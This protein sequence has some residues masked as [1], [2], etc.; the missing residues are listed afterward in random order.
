[1][2]C[3]WW[4]TAGLVVVVW[5]VWRRERARVHTSPAHHFIGS[6]CPARTGPRSIAT[7]KPGVHLRGALCVSA[8]VHLRILGALGTSVC[9]VQ[10]L[11]VRVRMWSRPRGAGSALADRPPD[12]EADEGLVR[13]EEAVAFEDDSRLGRPRTGRLRETE[14]ASLRVRFLRHVC[15]LSLRLSRRASRVEVLSEAPR[16]SA[17]AVSSDVAPARSMLMGDANDSGSAL[18]ASRVRM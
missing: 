13:A 8:R 11:C 3:V 16:P 10:R 5:H 17:A 18:G 1:M 7:C 12:V 15:V 6:S 2:V 9:R 4:P 14:V